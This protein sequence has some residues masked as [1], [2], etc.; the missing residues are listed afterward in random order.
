[1]KKIILFLAIGAM[2]LVSASNGKLINKKE[3]KKLKALKTVCVTVTV[4]NPYNGNSASATSCAETYQQAFH[5]ATVQAL[6]A[7]D[8]ME[9]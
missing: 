2:G 7:S 9:P 1:M 4:N 8:A 6:Q 3:Q 5:Q